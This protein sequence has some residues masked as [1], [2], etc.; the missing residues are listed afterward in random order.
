MEPDAS[1]KQALFLYS[2][3]KKM[4]S[5]K[6]NGHYWRQMQM[7]C[8]YKTGKRFSGRSM[9]RWE[10]IS[11]VDFKEAELESVHWTIWMRIETFG[12]LLRAQ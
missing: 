7:K 8:D 5:V 3:K 11:N 6:L 12:G 9:L 1:Q 10:D 2:S 4:N